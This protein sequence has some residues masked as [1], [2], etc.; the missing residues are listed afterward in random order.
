MISYNDKFSKKIT[1]F[2]V[3]APNNRA[4][5]YARLKLI[6]LKGEI[7]EPM[8]IVGDFNNI[9]SVIGKSSRQNISKDIIEWN[10]IINQVDLIDYFK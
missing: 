7:N 6:G 3:Y 2:D 5:K 1:I 9:L 10:S 8:I 4:S